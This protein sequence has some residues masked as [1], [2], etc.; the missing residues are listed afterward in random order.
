MKDIRRK[1]SN[2]RVN[3]EKEKIVFDLTIDEFKKL[4]KEAGITADDMNIKGYH[5]ARIND[6]GSYVYGNCRFIY[7]QQNYSERKVSEKSRMAS[8]KTLINFM[9][10]ESKSD[11]NKRMK[12]AIKNSK[13]YWDSLTD[14]E[15]NK[16]VHPLKEDEIKRRH[17]IIRTIPNKFGRLTIASKLIG[18]KPQVVGRFLKKY[19]IG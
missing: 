16:K 8:K 6:S 4:A 17:D 2:K 18:I 19:P 11:K 15:R 1:Y 3:A 5:L 12:K 7:Y 14:E 13:K 10:G 9:K